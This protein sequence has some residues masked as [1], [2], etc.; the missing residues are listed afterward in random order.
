MSTPA[1]RWRSPGAEGATLVDA[2][3]LVG[4]AGRIKERL[5]VWKQAGADGKIGSMLLG[6]GQLEAMELVAKEML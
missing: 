1:G 5:Q 4:P 6:T 2:C 3:H